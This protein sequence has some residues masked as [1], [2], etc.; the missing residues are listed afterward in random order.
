MALA[1][2]AALA[3]PLRRLQALVGPGWSTDAADD[4]AATMDAVHQMLTDVANSA[5]HAWSSTT[6][7]WSGTGADAAADFAAT[8]TSAIDAAADRARGM[9]VTAYAAARAVAGA[10]RRLQALV[11]EFEAK[12]S[13]LE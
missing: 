1:T 7:E 4:P 3:A 9:S 12:A 2:V 6:G 13:A 5:S 11:D 8:T 10:H